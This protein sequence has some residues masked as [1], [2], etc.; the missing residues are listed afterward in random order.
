VSCFKLSI[1]FLKDRPTLEEE[2]TFQGHKNIVSLHAR[3]IE[4]TK[5][6]NLT[7][8]GDC[9]VGVSANKA[10]NDLNNALK[11]KLRTKGT[12]VKITIVVEPCEF[13]LSGYGSNGLD[14][15]HEHDIVLRKSNYVDS[16]TLVVSCDKSALD[17]PRNIVSS[18]A[19]TQV[20]GIMRIAVE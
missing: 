2:I 6:S 20:K 8:N 18:L 9:I 5:D 13:Q 3:T 19:N 16:R 1:D 12:I 11:D 10:C 17:I 14:I 7:K 15:T 4:I